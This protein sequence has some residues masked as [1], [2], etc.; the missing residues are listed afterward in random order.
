ML[1]TTTTI[2][3]LKCSLHK[4]S[5]DNAQLYHGANGLTRRTETPL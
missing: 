2:T 3:G 5:P 1:A 4:P